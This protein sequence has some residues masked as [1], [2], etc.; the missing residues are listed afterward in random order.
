MAAVSLAM[1]QAARNRTDDPKM[2]YILPVERWEI[3][4]IQDSQTLTLAFLLPAGGELC[5]RVAQAEAQ[6][7]HEALGVL[8]GLGGTTPILK[9]QKH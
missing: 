1:G 9:S 2:R 5:F 7:M 6:H 8:L 3:E 4:P